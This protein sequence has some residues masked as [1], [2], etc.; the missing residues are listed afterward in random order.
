MKRSLD[1]MTDH[2]RWQLFPIILSPPNPI[3]KENY[4]KEKI[5]LE[6]GIGIQNIVRINHIGSTAV[7]DLI[8]KPT[9]DIIVEIKKETDLDKLISSMKSI[10][11]R[12][13]HKPQNPDPHAYFIKG[14]T[15]QGFRGQVFHVHVR[16]GGDWDEFY[17]RDYL[18]KHPETAHEYGEL[19]ILL[20][21]KYEHDRDAYTNAKTDF[22]KRITAL[23]RA[24]SQ[25]RY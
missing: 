7:P 24:E 16:Y 8:A 2:E 11:Y 25:I 13:I 3:W 23:A 14:Y 15:P 17:F 21:G 6:K 4:L 22:I 10:G 1:E 5:L 12:Y 18:R 9:I 19:K 20:K